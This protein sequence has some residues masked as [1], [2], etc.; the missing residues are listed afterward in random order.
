MKYAI[1]AR[2]ALPCEND[3]KKVMYI[4]RNDYDRITRANYSYEKNEEFD[5]GRR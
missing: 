5:I 4:Q 1:F 2:Y 3:W